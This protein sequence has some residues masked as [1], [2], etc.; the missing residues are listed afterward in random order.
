MTPEETQLRDLLSA[1]ARTIGQ[2]P[3]DAVRSRFAQ[4]QQISKA[5]TE[6]EIIRQQAEADS[7]EGDEA[8]YQAGPCTRR[9]ATWRRPPAGTAQPRRTTSP[10]HRSSSP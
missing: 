4:L 9:E 6:R 2:M 1:A 3:E 10:E 7:V 5:S 8:A